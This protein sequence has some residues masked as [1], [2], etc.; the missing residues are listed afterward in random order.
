MNY[1]ADFNSVIYKTLVPTPDIETILIM[2]GVT[3]ILLQ[4]PNQ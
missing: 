3:L 2:T 4:I 1:A